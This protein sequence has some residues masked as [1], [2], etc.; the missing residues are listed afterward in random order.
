MVACDIVRVLPVGHD[1]GVVVAGGGG[2]GGGGVGLVQLVDM[3]ATGD[4]DA[5]RAHVPRSCD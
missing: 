3:I 2:G 1:G 5:S 4:T